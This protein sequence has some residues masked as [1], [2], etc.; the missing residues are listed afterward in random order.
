MGPA[1]VF[2]PT[3]GQLLESILAT[4]T[5]L[6]PYNGHIWP[7]CTVGRFDL[8]PIPVS[9]VHSWPF[10][11]SELFQLC[12]NSESACYGHIYWTHFL[13]SW[14]HLGPSWPHL[15]TILVPSWPTSAPSW[16]IVA[17]SWAHSGPILALSCPILACLGPVFVVPRPFPSAAVVLCISVQLPVQLQLVGGGAAAPPRTPPLSI[18]LLSTASGQ[19]GSC[20]QFLASLCYHCSRALQLD[21]ANPTPQP[22]IIC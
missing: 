2:C 13:A 17:P 5:L 15:G 21:P 10:F 14:P 3:S 9:Y 16:T 11:A 22:N 12:E 18:R 7:L 20:L 1:A 19:E 4:R 8:C 6:D